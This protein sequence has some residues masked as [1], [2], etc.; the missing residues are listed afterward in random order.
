MMERIENSAA[1]LLARLRALDVSL[2]LD[3]ERLRVNAPKDSL[4]AELR[5]EIAAAKPDLIRFLR[6]SATR[7]LDG[8]PP[9]R[10][11]PRTGPLPLSFAQERLWF[12]HELGEGS[13]AYS[14]MLALRLRGSLDADALRWSMREIVRRHEVLR[15]TVGVVDGRP[16]QVIGADGCVDLVAEDLSSAPAPMDA[17][18]ER[19]VAAAEAPFSPSRGPLCRLLLL[20]VGDDDHVLLC[21]IAHLIADGWSMSV[22]FSELSALYAARVGGEGSPLAKLPVQYSDHAYWQH[23]WFEQSDEIAELRDYWRAQLAGAATLELPTDR[24]RPTSQSFRGAQLRFTIPAARIRALEAVAKREGCTLFMALL[25]SFDVLLARY[26]GQE[27]VVLGTPVANRT[28]AGSE[29]LI[30]LF[31]NSLVLRTDLSGEPSFL[32]L[33]HRVREVA[34]GAF[35]HRE[36]PF[37]RL[38]AELRP[39]RDLSR[40]PLFQVLFNFRNEPKVPFALEGVAVES[41]ELP[42]QTAKFDLNLELQRG[43]D[44]VSGFFEYNSDLFDRQ[45][46][47]RMER[48][49]QRLIEELAAAPDRCVWHAPMLTDSEDAA[50]VECNAT[51]ASYPR[52][53]S[54]V[55]LFEERAAAQPDATAVRCGEHVLTYAELNARANQLARHLRELGAGPERLVGLCVERGVDMLVGSMAIQKSGSAY[56]PLDP[57]YPKDR[58]EFIA[59]DAGLALL[60]TQEAVRD[61]LPELAARFVSMDGEAESIGAR[62]RD[63]LGPA[64]AVAAESLA[65]VIFTSGSTGRPKGVQIEHRALLNFLCTMAERPGLG[66]DDVLLAVTTISFDIAGLELY[67]PLLVGATVVIAD[68]DETG[69]GARLLEIVREQ[70]VTVMQATPATWQLLLEAGWQGGDAQLRK[71]LCGGEA[72]PRDLAERLLETGAEVWNMYGPTET[73]VWSLCQRVEPGIGAVPLGTPIGNTE[74]LLLD[75]HGQPVPRGAIG[76]IFL[77]GDGLARG[78]WQREDLTQERFVAHPLRAGARLYDTGDLARY[79]NDGT[80]EFLGRVDHQVKVR[81]FRIELGE[82]EHALLGHAAVT[83]CAVVARQLPRGD[84]QLEAHVV[85]HANG[86]A[87]VS[88]LRAHLRDRLP[89]YMVPPAFS[90]HSALPLTPNGKVDRKALI[91]SARGEVARAKYEPPSTPTETRLAALWQDV[92]EVERVG[93]GD[94]FFDLGGHSLLAMRVVFRIKKELGVGVLPMELLLNTLEQLAELCDRRGVPCVPSEGDGPPLAVVDPEL[95]QRR[96]ARPASNGVS[97]ARVAPS[98]APVEVRETVVRLGE[99]ESL[100]GVLTEPVAG[101]SHAIACVLLNAGGVHRVGPQRFYVKLARRLAELGFTCLRFDHSGIGDSATHS[102]QAGY[103]ERSVEEARQAFDYLGE[104]RSFDRFVTLGFCWGADNALRVACTDERVVGAAMADFYAAPSARYFMRLYWRRLASWRSWRNLLGGGSNV[105]RE[106]K[107]VVRSR[108]KRMWQRNDDPLEKAIVSLR[109]PAAILSDFDML[110]DRGGKMCFVYMR[111]APSFDHYHTK[112]RDHLAGL[113]ARRAVAVHFLPDADH[114]VTQLYNQRRLLE[115]LVDWMR[116]VAREH[117]HVELPIAM[118]R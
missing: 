45:S 49:L 79:C 57:T 39:E 106:A 64:A 84:Y 59:Q 27:D 67:L 114:L 35:H 56:V 20:H 5:A 83:E 24:P 96:R 30:G 62:D 74:V 40:S 46:V 3:G 32:D 112:Y 99:R 78:Y 48:H 81:G 115:L 92:L 77:G 94:N 80:L 6:D 105:L 63:N 104:T 38:V 34:L 37:E 97:K 72:F 76:R 58:I 88:E 110:A 60:V 65:Y 19:L 75:R 118:A 31:L 1:G 70:R 25:A 43:A 69:N 54:L 47:A 87:T 12:L 53:R 90:S 44:G 103:G 10:L 13:A 29:N 18:R 15:S 107:E 23:R 109:T 55:A 85:L 9:L 86:S 98:G 36:M 11:A 16:V 4:T 95:N 14:L 52:D 2:R 61:R 89:E 22:F 8:A 93:R 68:A 51:V 21:T 116:E 100:V 71:V 117:A 73:T 33:L 17:A 108:L 111:G 42:N 7:E 82:I 102:D 26:S 41:I 101:G 113:E 28:A 91:E 66:A 50:L